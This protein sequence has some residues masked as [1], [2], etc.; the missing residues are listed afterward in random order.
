MSLPST[1][2][3]EAYGLKRSFKIVI[4]TDDLP[5]FLFETYGFYKKSTTTII[6]WLLVQGGRTKARAH[7]NSTKDLIYLSEAIIKNQIKV[8][9]H[10]VQTLRSNISAW[11]RVAKC[12][13][14]RAASEDHGATTSHEFFTSISQRAYIDL[15]GLTEEEQEILIAPEREK[16]KLSNAFE[17]L[18]TENC[19]EDCLEYEDDVSHKEKGSAAGTISF[20]VAATTTNIAYQI[21]R[22]L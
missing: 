9:N 10:I 15:R 14:K 5:S 13:K 19:L 3:E 2:L 21:A 16:F 4:S 17:H 7:I 6:Q 11:T 18:H 1:R 22:W 12:F 20:V 8:P